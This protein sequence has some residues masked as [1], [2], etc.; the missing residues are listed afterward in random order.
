MKL[1]GVLRRST[2]EERGGTE[3]RRHKPKRKNIF[4]RGHQWRGRGGL[5]RWTGPDPW[6]ESNVN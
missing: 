5:A 1:M 2:R 6:K 4:P 3:I